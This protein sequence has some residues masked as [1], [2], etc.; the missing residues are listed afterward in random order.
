[1]PIKINIKN[2]MKLG[3][4]LIVVGCTSQSAS[5]LTPTPTPKREL[6]IY[7]WGTYIAPQLL[8]DFETAYGVTI[9]Y[10]EFDSDDALLDDLRAGST[11]DIVVPSDTLM[12]L[13]RSKGLLA[14]LNHDNIPNLANLAPEFANPSY[15]PQNRYSVPYQWGTIGIGYHIGRT[16]RELTSW[17]DLFDPAF[18]GRVGILDDYN[19]ALGAILMLLGYSPNS[20]N[21]VQLEEAGAFLMSHLNQLL[22]IGDTAQDYL[23]SGE[24]DIVVEFNGDIAQLMRDDPDIRFIIPEEGGYIWVDVL[25]IPAN[26]PNKDLA[27]L[28][29][30][31]MLDPQ[32]GATL[33][34]EIRYGSP[35]LASR[36]FLNPDDLIDPVIYP[37]EDV[38]RRL[39][40]Q[41][42]IDAQTNALYAD[43]W[44][45]FRQMSH[46][47][48]SD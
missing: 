7:N 26:S 35:N 10:E 1:M 32:N 41:A 28:F 43:I 42:Y 30:N 39:F 45:Q 23:A 36:P 15:D 16:G 34:N 37:S 29:I 44:E 21:V 20:L 48:L 11:H 25:A 18:A 40:Y 14:R 31:F 12:P 5:L 4:M 17:R 2:L 13:M 3:I 24:L 47:S 38:Q 8:T 9:R 27:E 6:A 19:L 46:E 22:I 33:S